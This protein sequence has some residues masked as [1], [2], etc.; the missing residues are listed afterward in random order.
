MASLAL[1]DWRAALAE[2]A[3]AVAGARG[4]AVMFEIDVTRPD[5]TRIRARALLSGSAWRTTT[6]RFWQCAAWWCC[7]GAGA[8]AACPVASFGIDA[9][10]WG[11]AQWPHASPAH[12]HPALGEEGV[13]AQAVCGCTACSCAGGMGTSLARVGRWL[14]G[15]FSFGAAYDGAIH[16]SGGSAAAWCGCTVVARSA[17]ACGTDGC[18][19]GGTA[20]G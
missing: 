3:T 15:A 18:C 19:R 14:R 8:S 2:L 5:G 7:P 20:R 13:A 9:R 17:C 4:G 6:C 11:T 10:R 1:D 12:E 16:Q